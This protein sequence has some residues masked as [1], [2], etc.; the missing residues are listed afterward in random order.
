[1]LKRVMLLAL[2]AVCLASAKNYNFIISEP[3]Y[4]GSA[5]L[6]PGVYTVKVDGSQVVLINS[7]G[8]RMDEA[9]KVEATDQKYD[10]TSV[11]ISKTDGTCRIESVRLGG[12]RNQVVF[13]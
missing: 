7:E 11:L 1:M 3:T 4:A 10:D 13:E 12:A 9:A 6:K 5:Q 8:Q 2:L